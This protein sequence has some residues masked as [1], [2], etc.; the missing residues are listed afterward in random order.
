MNKS[1][2]IKELAT[3]LAKFQGEVTAAPFNST[4]P[5][6]KNR[7]ADLGSIIQTAKPILAK[8]GLAVSQLVES[9]DDPR[10]GVTTIVMHSS[11]EWI[12]S[13]VWMERGEEKGKSAAQVAGSIISYLRRYALSAALGMHADDDTDGNQPPARQEHKPAPAKANGK[14]QTI[15]YP[16]ELA[17]VTTSEGEFYIELPDDKLKFMAASIRKALGKPDLTEDQKSNYA[18]KADVIK[19]IQAIRAG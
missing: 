12:S 10:V 15:I 17:V 11:G 1:D 5:F 9:D 19:Q 14:E 4:N 2:S 7:Y 8:H 16:P 6:L 3:A 18:M 13:T